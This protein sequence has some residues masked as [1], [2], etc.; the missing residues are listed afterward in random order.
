V[1]RLIPLDAALLRTLPLPEP[2]EGSKDE[3]GRALIIGGSV[4]V[5]G[6]ALLAATAALRAGAGKLQIATVATMATGMAFAMPEALVMGLPETPSGGISRRAGDIL[7]PKVQ[8]C[9]AVVI[10]PGMVEEED[11]DILTRELLEGAPDTAWLL[12]AAALCT[13]LSLATVLKLL[14]APA[15][16]TPHAGEM[17]N[18]LGASRDDVEAD[19]LDAARRVAGELG[20]I[21]VMKGSETGIVAPDGT[22]WLYTGGGVGLATSGSGDTLAGIIVGLLAR[23]A[24]PQAAALWG[25]YLH[26]E[27]GRLLTKS[28]G[29]LGFLAREIPAQVPGLLE[30]FRGA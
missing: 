26:G 14:K 17:A 21:V 11:A 23:G 8:R 29:T 9:D 30:G 4:E 16:I 15:I 3:R 5:P 20:V 6:G 1:S 13:V 22:S 18:L 10:G 12:D 27:A 2:V 19:P 24:P 28:V 7:L 25:V